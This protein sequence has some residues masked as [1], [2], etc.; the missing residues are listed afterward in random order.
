M[1]W[2]A[3]LAV[4]GCLLLNLAGC[5]SVSELWDDWFG[6]SARRDVPTPLSEFKP[7]VQLS[8]KQATVGAG[9]TAVL[10]PGVWQ[11]SVFAASAE[12]RLVRFDA[13]L[14]REL[15]RLE[16]KERLSAGVGVGPAGVVVAGP[17]GDVLAFDHG[18]RLLWRT[19]VSSEV[20]APPAV[21]TD[22]VYVRAL[23][24]RIHALDAASG[25]RKWF[26]QRNI[27]ALTVRNT[28]GLLLDRNGL[29]AGFGGGKL[30]ALE[31]ASGAVAWEATVAQPRGVS[32]LERIADVTSTPVTDGQ[33]ICAA[34][35]QGRVACFD[36]NTGAPAWGREISSFTG[37]ALDGRNLYV[38]ETKGVVHALDKGSGASVWKQDKLLHRQLSG[39]AVHRGYVVVGDLAGYV[40]F[41]SREDGSFAARIATDGSPIRA[42]PQVLPQGVLVQTLK[43]G[44]Y[45]IGL[46]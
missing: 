45:L 22:T 40:H 15:W 29:F 34:A 44:L 14:G 43:G 1:R 28:A 36:I 2:Q 19:R 31:A 38:S 6:T 35:F 20:L 32:E 23:D 8:L 41:L 30:V 3:R 26:Y 39:P 13:T 5:A 11:Q 24:G 12:G 17:K 42:T 37:I 10:V 7:T 46:D 27:P 16:L 9:G 21:G 25:Q 4:I 33:L 18:G